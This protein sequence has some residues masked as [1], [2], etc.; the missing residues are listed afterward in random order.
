MSN[1]KD[2]SQPNQNDNKSNQKGST[3]K[4]QV[5][6]DK[7]ISTEPKMIKESF[8]KTEKIDTPKDNK[9]E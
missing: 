6:P 5:N 2:N 3:P 8:N 1:E 4:Q 9:K 7:V